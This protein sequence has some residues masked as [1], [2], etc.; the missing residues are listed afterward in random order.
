MAL[1]IPPVPCVAPSPVAPI[2]ATAPIT[3][4]VTRYAR[5]DAATE[6]GRRT[7]ER[8]LALRAQLDRDVPARTIA[9]TLLLATWNI[10]EF[11][12]PSFGTRS[13]ECLLYIAE[14]VA[15]FDLVAVQEVREI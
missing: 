12:A 13:D 2:V 4:I 1:V 7:A 8:L 6:E 15:R 11:D 10:R 5:L 3:P 9:D 14:I